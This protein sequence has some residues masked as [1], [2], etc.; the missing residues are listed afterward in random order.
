MVTDI[1]WQWPKPRAAEISGS[2]G[3]R[4]DRQAERPYFGSIPDFSQ[5]KPGYLL[6]GVPPKAPRN[7]GI[8]AGDIIV[9]LGESRIGNLEDLTVRCESSNRATECRSRSNGARKK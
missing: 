3:R 6:M 2:E 5:D 7:A 1:A 9:Q 4:P 8:T